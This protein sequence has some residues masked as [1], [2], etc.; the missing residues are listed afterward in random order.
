MTNHNVLPPALESPNPN[1]YIRPVHLTDITCLHETCWPERPH[2]VVHQLIARAQQSARQGRGLGV[3]IQET[4][5]TPDALCGYGQLTMWSRGGEISDLVV[6]EA[7]RGQGLGTAIIQYLVRAARE[8]HAPMVE[9]GAAF[10]NPGAMAL[11]R[12]LG[13]QDDHTIM[14]NLG[15]GLEEVLY[16]RL[17]L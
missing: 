9:I 10:S 4:R 11:Y 15:E 5:D 8:M 12:R 13:F 6:A 3:V 14:L 1:I 16:L 7:Y 17:D 2:S